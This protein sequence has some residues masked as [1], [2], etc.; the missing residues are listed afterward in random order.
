MKK[1]IFLRNSTLC[2]MVFLFY[3]CANPH[4]RY[5][6]PGN[7][8]PAPILQQPVVLPTAPCQNE[9]ASSINAQ[10]ETLSREA[11][12]ALSSREDTTT[13]SSCEDTPSSCE[14]MPPSFGGDTPPSYDEATAPPPPY[15]EI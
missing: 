9:E 3:A 13:S 12:T 7:T 1:H 10:N 8:S 4:P 5:T 11:S 14:D 6:P 2:I 15:E